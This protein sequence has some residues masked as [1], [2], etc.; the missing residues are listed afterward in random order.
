MNTLHDLMDLFITIKMSHDFARGYTDEGRKLPDAYASTDKKKTNAKYE[1]LYVEL[2]K[3][4]KVI[5]KEMKI[6]EK[7]FL[8]LPPQTALGQKANKAYTDLYNRWNQHRH[9]NTLKDFL[10]NAET[11]E[12]KAS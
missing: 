2:A 5:L 10:K 4:K 12:K 11:F 8:E 9:Q 3:I 6:N 7:Q 1:P